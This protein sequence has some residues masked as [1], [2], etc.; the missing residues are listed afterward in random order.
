MCCGPD[1]HK[2]GIMPLFQT[3]TH[4]YIG[5]RRT[6]ADYSNVIPIRRGRAMGDAAAP[7]Q[8]QGQQLSA[9]L[10][11]QLTQAGQD[12]QTLTAA[13]A[14]NA[15]VAAA[16]QVN[17]NTA[18]SQFAVWSKNVTDWMNQN[19]G[20]WNVIGLALNPVALYNF[21]QQGAAYISQG[22]VLVN[23]INAM[24]AQLASIATQ[25]VGITQGDS[26]QY[27]ALAATAY[28]N[29]DTAQGD[30]YS[31]LAQVAQSTALNQAVN[32][33]NPNPLPPKPPTDFLT[34]IENNMWWVAGIGAIV[35]LGPPL[36]KKL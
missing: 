10:S 23:S 29:G 33:N 32:V 36:I 30:Y 6:L 15:T 9:Q 12:L 19:S 35:F 14:S 24:K 8:A 27:A 4:S 22:E 34:W 7:T 17:L 1:A 26:T 25:N 13:A 18:N 21:I 28:E 20:I 3:E 31:G 5:T 16:I 2:K 11:A